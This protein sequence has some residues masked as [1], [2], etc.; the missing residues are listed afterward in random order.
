MDGHQFDETQSSR[1]AFLEN[2]GAH[3]SLE[4]LLE[5]SGRKLLQKTTNA[6]EIGENQIK[7]SHSM[8]HVQKGNS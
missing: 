4:R 6:Q 7:A 2:I 3:T 8:T 1:R 5:A